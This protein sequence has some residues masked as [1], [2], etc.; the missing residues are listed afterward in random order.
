MLHFPLRVVRKSALK[1]RGRTGFLY[2]D[3]KAELIEGLTLVAVIVRWSEVVWRCGVGS[4][5]RLFEHHFS[6]WRT[7]ENS[8]CLAYG[9]SP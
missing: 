1:V 6:E 4:E 5:L 7:T 9:P 8:V 3:S 2:A